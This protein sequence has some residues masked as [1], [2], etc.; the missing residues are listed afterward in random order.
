M[1]L[2][3]AAFRPDTKAK[4]AA[5]NLIVPT[6]QMVVRRSL[7]PVTSR[8]LYMS[9]AAWAAATPAWDI[10]AAR[11]VSLA[12]SIKADAIPPQVRLAVESEDLGSEGVDFFGAGLSEQLFDTPAAIARIWRSRVARR[13]L[14]VSAAETRDP[15]GRA[16]AFAWRLLQG[17]PRHVTIE[18]LDKAGRRARITLDWTPPFPIS[19]EN[20]IRSARIDV[21]VFANNGVHD[22]APAIL[23]WYL[24]P[25]ETRTIETG[26]DG[27]PRTARIDHA[28]PAKAATYA[29]PML[30][31]RADWSDHFTYGEDGT[32]TGWVRS[33]DGAPDEIF[34][35]DGRRLPEA[36]SAAPAGPVPVTYPLA[37]DPAGRLLVRE[38]DAGE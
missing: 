18:P 14:M 23:S 33:R 4:L 22:S 26:P 12:N 11:M 24:P 5:E 3:L 9:A 31:P 34:A 30:V 32:L 36:G 10:N 27:A 28:D 37:R 21:G 29:D 6:V 1:A 20:P 13:S 38:T 25:S 16:L 35:P 17:D 2:V 15:N 19:K 7:N 8:P